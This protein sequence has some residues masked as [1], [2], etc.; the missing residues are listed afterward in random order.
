M[1]QD[2]A[3]A[4][5]RLLSCEE[6]ESEKKNNP[7]FRDALAAAAASGRKFWEVDAA[8]AHRKQTCANV[9]P[10]RPNTKDYREFSLRELAPE[11]RPIKG[12]AFPS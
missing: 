4:K 2:E 5:W 10:A 6:V 1:T 9:P 3:V 8:G 7:E 11:D 12:A